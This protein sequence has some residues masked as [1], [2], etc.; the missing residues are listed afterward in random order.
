MPRLDS[1]SSKPTLQAFAQGAA[2]QFTQPVADF[3]A[4]T[5]NVSTLI[6]RYKKYTEK[7]RFRIPNTKRGMGGRAVRLVFEATD[8]TYNCEPHAIDYPVDNL[9]ALEESGLE[10]ALME[11]ATATAEVAGLDH[12]VRVINTALTAIGAGTNKTWNASADPIDDLDSA[13][14]TVL[15]AAKYGSLMGVGVLFG[16]TA[17]K[18]AKNSS[19]VKGRFIVAAGSGKGGGG[20][21]Q[22]VPTIAEFGNLLVAQPDVRASYMVVDTAAEGLPESINFVLDSSIIIFARLANPTR[23]DPSFMKTFRLAGQW[24]KPGSY[25]SEDGRSEI[26]KFDWSADVQV[27]N[28]AAAVRLNIS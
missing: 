16:T 23:R 22:V 1:I 19:G 26:A 9:E 15:K 28:S 4:P 8:A 17:W 27:T 18:I 24:M 25:T 3:L 14:L 5:V 7:N 11:G 12:E 20:V 2:Q 10:N 6:G 13:I 21:G